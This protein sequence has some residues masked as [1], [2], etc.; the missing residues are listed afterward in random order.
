MTPP[1]CLRAAEPSSRACKSHPLLLAKRAPQVPGQWLKRVLQRRPLA[2]VEQHLDRKA[3]TKIAAAECST[4]L[5]ELI[6]R[7]LNLGTEEGLAALFIREAVR[8][9]GADRSGKQRQR[10]VVDA[11]EADLGCLTTI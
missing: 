1:L 5:A 10:L 8:R 11:H 6:R 3:G 9:N 7:D 4:H 2:H